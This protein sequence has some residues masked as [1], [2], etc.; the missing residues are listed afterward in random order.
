MLSKK[1]G[2]K[3]K[4]WRA[5][6]ETVLQR[7]ITEARGGRW[8][9]DELE[10]ISPLADALYREKLTHAV[11]SPQHK[12]LIDGVLPFHRE[13]PSTLIFIFVLA[14]KT[15]K[16]KKRTCRDP[17]PSCP[18]RSGRTSSASKPRTMNG[19]TAFWV[20]WGEEPGTTF[21]RALAATNGLTT[22]VG[23]P[24]LVNLVA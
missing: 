12:F 22:R 21:F 3:V 19:F 14:Y 7:V 10:S 6:S 15:G 13:W 5:R 11:R 8:T 1:Y 16:A 23:H 9:V 24:L 4:V 17:V 18:A 20:T 2:V